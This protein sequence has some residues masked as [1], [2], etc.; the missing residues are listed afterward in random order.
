MGATMRRRTLLAATLMLPLAGCALAED[1]IAPPAASPASA[2]LAALEGRFGA[3]L[4]VYAISPISGKEVRHRPDELFPMCSTFKGLAV[5]A[6]LDKFPI[7]HLEEVVPF[8]SRALLD[9]SP[10]SKENVG[11]GMTVRELCDAAIRYS[12]NTA[13]NLLLEQIGG[14]A[15]L[16]AF[17]RS[18][19]DDVTRLDRIEPELNSAEPGDPR[20]TTSPRAIGNDYREL[21]L[22]KRLATD[23]KFELTR[24]LT[25]NTTGD[26]RIRAGLPPD[27]KVGDKT[28]T[29]SYGT[30]NDVAIAWPPSMPAI[31]VSI[32]STKPAKDAVA[33]SALIAE[34]AKIVAAQLGT[35][36]AFVPIPTTINTG[37]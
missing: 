5:A 27:W 9:G 37:G 2:D 22:G 35:P 23:T 20:D 17:L 28:G 16:T 7:S 13:A 34:A 19:G 33:D 25:T 36:D 6:L 31:V 11:S 4:G 14:P 21:V 24:W 30:A 15:E 26:D 10:I 1:H 32:L 3:R 29:G 12:D 8:T 18:L